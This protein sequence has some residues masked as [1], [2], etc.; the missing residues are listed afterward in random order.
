[1]ALKPGNLPIRLYFFVNLKC[2]ISTIILPLGITYNLIY[3]VNYCSWAVFMR[4][5][6]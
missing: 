6:S 1:M 3:D 5:R 2:Q 4:Y